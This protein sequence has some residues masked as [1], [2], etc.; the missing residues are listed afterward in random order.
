MNQQ[1]FQEGNRPR[2][3]NRKLSWICGLMFLVGATST[4][5]VQIVGRV[6]LSEIIAFLFVPYFWLTKREKWL[7][8]N[9]VKCLWALGLLFLGII[10]ADIVNGNFFW[11]SVRAFARPI[12]M[13]GFLLFFIPV[14][15]RDPLSLVYM[16]YG[17]IVGG[18]IKYFRPSAFEVEAAQYLEGYAGVVFRILPMIAAVVVAIA[19]Y[20]YP[21]SRILA[22]GAF[23]LGMVAL[24]AVGAPRSSLL[25]LT[26][27]VMLILLVAAFKTARSRRIEITARKVCLIAMVVFMG[28]ISIYAVYLYAAPRGLLGE[29]QQIKYENQASQRFGATPWGLVLSGRAQVYGAV[30]GIIDKPF[31][32]FGSWRHD[33]TYV[34]VIDA[35]GDVG[36]DPK[37]I[38]NLRKGGMT[39]GAG[40]S[41]LFQSWVENGLMTAIA[42]IAIY[43]IAL[44]VL[45]FSIRYE[46]R[47]TPFLIYTFVSFSLDFL[48]SPPDVGLRLAVG[49]FLA[50]YVVFMDKRRPLARVDVLAR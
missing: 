27:V 19:V 24:V 11:Y 28:S 45:L 48:I 14:L 46:S 8:Q 13:L 15:S 34:Y 42:Y 39:D 23:V 7:N 30:L 21:R 43:V 3:W 29:D 44:K 22:A 6:S 16:V 1:H 25:V 2:G 12:F 32:G 9:M 41:V 26:L 49:L 38:D 40:H 5:D 4:V 35:I 31:F 20:I 50:I 33:L 18:V 47:L 10:I 36:A 17:G 37:V